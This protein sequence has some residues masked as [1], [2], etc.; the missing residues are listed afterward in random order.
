MAM[1]NN[2]MVYIYIPW[3][4]LIIP[5]KYLI[6]EYPHQTTKYWLF[7]IFTIFSHYSLISQYI[8]KKSTHV[9]FVAAAFEVHDLNYEE[10]KA[11]YPLKRVCS[12][13]HKGFTPK[14]WLKTGQCW[15]CLP[16]WG[17]LS[18]KQIHISAFALG[19]FWGN[20]KGENK[21]RHIRHVGSGCRALKQQHVFS[22]RIS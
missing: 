5:L 7:I 10:D 15:I 2:Q 22:L 17:Y 18:F 9:T 14:S 11:C 6:H 8:A 13:L 1:L 19:D 12:L 20:G 3:Y 4:A 21:F 16:N